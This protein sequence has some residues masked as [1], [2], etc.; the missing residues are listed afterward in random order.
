[1]PNLD[2]IRTFVEVYRT[3]TI[4][5][6]ARSLHLSQPA[7]S[8]QVKALENKVGKEL[9]RRAAR[10]VEPTE[11]GLQLVNAVTEHIDALDEALGTTT[12][13][14]L[15]GSTLYLGGPSEFIA[16]RVIPS[17]KEFMESGLRLRMYFNTDEP[18]MQRLT[19]GDLDIAV[20]TA[21]F[22]S[23]GIESEPLS[24]EQL[25]LVAA[26]NRITEIGEVTQTR[27]SLR[28]LSQL[29][30]VAYNEELPLIT[31]YWQSVFRSRPTNDTVVVANSMRAMIALAKAGAGIAVLPKHTC[32]LELS[33]GELQ[34]V[35]EP[36][37]TPENP[38]FLTWRS[39][40]L[41]NVSIAAVRNHLLADA[42]SW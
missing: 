9:F 30:L 33:T 20:T 12:T 28:K 14:G 38:L 34:P 15:V 11:A 22:S 19:H 36:R 25:V 4:T 24:S 27:V 23:R 21:N 40:S 35:L 17:L 32:E 26:P 37:R 39:G 42:A 41:R 8:L 7:V 2:L 16:E 6:A 1:M 18:V 13:S 3:G 29:P 10:G 31:E 5:G